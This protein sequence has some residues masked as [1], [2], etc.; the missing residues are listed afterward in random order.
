MFI[1]NSAQI[2]Q[3]I[4]TFTFMAQI[5]E[6]KYFAK[7]NVRVIYL[8]YLQ[9]NKQNKNQL[10]KINKKKTEKLKLAIEYGKPQQ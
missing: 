3:T 10:G 8:I 1:H 5:F 7:M 6:M 2:I 9:W 4:F